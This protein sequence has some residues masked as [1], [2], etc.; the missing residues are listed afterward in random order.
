[1]VAKIVVEPDL[2]Q[3]KVR[4]EGLLSEQDLTN[5]HPN[6]LW[7]EEEKLGIAEARQVIVHLA[8]K[9]YQGQSQGVVILQADNLTEEAQNAL[10]KTLEEPPLESI[11]ILGA[12]TEDNFLPTVLSRCQVAGSESRTKN[13]ELGEKDQ[14]QFEKLINSDLEQRFQLIEKLEDREKFLE[15]M[16]IYFRRKLLKNSAGAATIPPQGWNLE[17]TRDLLLA[18]KWAKQNVNIRA[19]LEYLMLKLRNE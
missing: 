19:I 7:L 11:I 4:I 17:F 8:L 18:Q 2:E 15:K 1:M 5:P 3:R 12:T 16:V 6:L 10:L 13:L 9:P 14:Q